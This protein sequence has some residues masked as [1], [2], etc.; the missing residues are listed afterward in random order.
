MHFVAGFV[1][2]AHHLHHSPYP[3][4]MT[5]P[6]VD[7]LILGPLEVRRGG[8]PVLTTAGLARTL[9]AALAVDAGRM[10]S[11]DRLV[12]TLWGHEPPPRA[13]SNLQTL[14]SRVR[15]V[16]EPDRPR[17]SA[18]SH[19]LREGP[20]YCLAVDPGRV[21]ALQ[22][23][24]QV[25]EGD[26]LLDLDPDQAADRYT[27]AL[28]LWRGDALADFEFEPF[29]QG[30][31]AD[32]QERRI[33]A[34]ESLAAAQLRSGAWS[35]AATL[36]ATM[37]RDH[38]LRE[39]L[40]GHYI[41]ALA[42]LDRQ[43]EALRAY[44]TLRDALVTQLGIEPCPALRDLQ[45]R[46]LDQTP[47][48][49]WDAHA[50]PGRPSAGPILSAAT[51]ASTLPVAAL[52]TQT[53]ADSAA[54]H[55]AAARGDWPDAYALLAPAAEGELEP[56]DLNTL[57]EAAMFTGRPQESLRAREAAHDAWTDDGEMGAA[58]IAA[59]TLSL[60]HAARMKLAAAGGWLHRAETLLAD[61]DDAP[62][63]G[64][65]AWA[66]AM[67][68]I[69]QGHPDAAL[70]QLKRTG[71]LGREFGIAEL[72]AL[73]ISFTGIVHAQCGDVE[74]GLD[75]M[76]QGMTWAL[77]GQLAPFLSGLIFCRTIGTCYDLGDYRRAGEWMD[78]IGYCLINSGVGAFPGDCETHRLKIL[79][80][81]GAWDECERQAREA[82]SS[83]ERMDVSHVGEAM[84]ALGEILRR[85]GA[86]DR[87]AV[88]FERAA[89]NGANPQPGSALLRM[90]TEA[91]GEAQAQI[92]L[93]LADEWREPHR[94]PM[95]LAHVE[96][97]LA[98]GDDKAAE[99]SVDELA[100]I[101][102]HYPGTAFAASSALAGGLSNEAKGDLDGA[103]A[104]LR[105]A[106]D[107]WRQLAAPYDEARAH[108]ALARVDAARGD[109]RE[110]RG[111]ARAAVAR[112]D[113]LG[114]APA[115]SQAEA[116]LAT[117][118]AQG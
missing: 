8:E 4:H 118:V 54:A 110:A 78:E 42:R 114:A 82:T 67:F 49:D 45:H 59:V 104:G 71:E 72:E 36:L 116:V 5:A 33:N 30:A 105:V 44:D 70:V 91:G 64:F 111:H 57:A 65:L 112:F 108:T 83:M 7:Y 25:A 35:D 9:V 13:V 68:A 37:V 61:M 92:E 93:A 77:S 56:A 39:P 60:H 22:F 84:Y 23:A 53:D 27:S 28:D 98:N 48:D 86:F 38:P 31:I 102:T 55:D 69:A 97:A 12:E 15:D 34:V 101:A 100:G 80:Q 96:I 3:G 26:R 109:T 43:A 87:A 17:R 74:E 29:S 58:A 76:D 32:L 66:G 19:L 47:I 24:A 75:L 113:Q 11:S 46:L 40:W 14:V 6:S 106:V 89:A 50:A 115:Q 63:H 2:L 95:L 10:V 79:V 73:A 52:V 103:H 51:V 94:V 117:I 99:A 81:R 62:P 16:L 88:A 85:R 107:A 20:G 41:A 90:D 21:D 1:L 18:G